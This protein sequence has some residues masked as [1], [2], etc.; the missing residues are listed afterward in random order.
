MSL[1]EAA[2]CGTPAVATAV[3]GHRHAVRDGVTGLLVDDPDELVAALVTVLTDERRRGQLGAAARHWAASLT[4][5]RTA[6][7]LLGL[8]VRVSRSPAGG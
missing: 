2:A 7:E 3:T 5:D 6:T 1:T 8:L 4:W